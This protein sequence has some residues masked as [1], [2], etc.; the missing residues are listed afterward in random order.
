MDGLERIDSRRGEGGLYQEVVEEVLC[1]SG[2]IIYLL[3]F[4]SF[5]GQRALTPHGPWRR[6]STE[7][8]P[9][10]GISHADSNLSVG[11]FYPFILLLIMHHLP[12]NNCE[13]MRKTRPLGIYCHCHGIV[14]PDHSKSQL[15]PLLHFPQGTRII[16][17]TTMTMP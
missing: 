12:D 16:T 5:V 15:D 13:S 4:V 1:S 2:C 10:M 6:T 7:T 11:L 9:R 17:E 3:V 14:P 8:M